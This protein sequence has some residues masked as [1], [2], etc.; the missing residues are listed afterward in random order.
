MSIRLR[1]TFAL[2]LCL[3]LLLSLS[4]VY[5]FSAAAEVALEPSLA[6]VN[7]PAEANSGRD[8]SDPPAEGFEVKYFFSGVMDNASTVTAIHCTNIGTQGADIRIELYSWDMQ[9]N[10]FVDQLLQANRTYTF[11][12]SEQGFFNEWD[13]LGTGFI[14]QGVGRII[15]EQDRQVICTAQ[16]LEK[17]SGIPTFMADLTLV[18]P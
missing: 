17:T 1:F 4:L 15:V 13:N 9:D 3:F 5:T 6:Q 12:S 8:P 18:T 10:Y 16:V 14:E 2:A 7:E 11:T